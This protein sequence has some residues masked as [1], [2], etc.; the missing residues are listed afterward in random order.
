MSDTSKRDSLIAWARNSAGPGSNGIN[1]MADALEQAE[2]ELATAKAVAL[3]AEAT[4]REY[5]LRLADHDGMV[6]AALKVTDKMSAGNLD[7]KHAWEQLRHILTVIV[8]SNE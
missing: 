4:T 6:K 7:V 2:R 3:S 5:R 1:E 8:E